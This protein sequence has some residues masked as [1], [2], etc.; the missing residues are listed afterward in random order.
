MSE[1]ALGLPDCQEAVELL[2]DCQKQAAKLLPEGDHRHARIVYPHPKLL[3]FRVDL[4][5]VFLDSSGGDVGEFEALEAQLVQRVVHREPFLPAGKDEHLAR[6][7]RGGHQDCV[8]HQG[9]SC[10]DDCVA[11]EDSRLDAELG[12]IA[13]RLE[14]Q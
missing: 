2:A 3:Q 11:P 14:F 10:A 13:D 9:L 4:A 12:E 1:E 5:P 6:V 8:V 7:L